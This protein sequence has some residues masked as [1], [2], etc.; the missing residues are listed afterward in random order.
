MPCELLVCFL[1]C[2]RADL[3]HAH[4]VLDA[5]FKCTRQRFLALPMYGMEWIISTGVHAWLHEAAHWLFLSCTFAYKQ[6]HKLAARRSHDYL[7]QTLLACLPPMPNPNP[8]P[9]DPIMESMSHT[10]FFSTSFSSLCNQHC[11]TALPIFARLFLSHCSLFVLS[12]ACLVTINVFPEKGPAFP[13][14]PIFDLRSSLMLRQLACM[15]KQGCPRLLGPG[16]FTQQK[17][18]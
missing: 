1:H 13:H 5:N 15:A 11:R 8:T 6:V 18:I 17:S 14:M 3:Q 16:L 7:I 10:H 2:V 9:P 4:R 12:Q